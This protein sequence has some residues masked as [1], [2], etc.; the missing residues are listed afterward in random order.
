MK[1]PLSI[2]NGIKNNTANPYD[3]T[4]STKET[5]SDSG[6]WLKERHTSIE[7]WTRGE[8]ILN[9]KPWNAKMKFRTRAPASYTVQMNELYKLIQRQ[10]TW[11]TNHCFHISFETKWKTINL[12][13]SRG[14]CSCCELVCGSDTESVIILEI[15]AL[16][17]AQNALTFPKGE[18]VSSFENV[19]Q[20]S[21]DVKAILTSNLWQTSISK[22]RERLLRLQN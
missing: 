19:N 13:V 12:I 4:K 11:Y 3:R 20:C 5:P 22:K 18:K 21:D 6:G 2:T 10:M 16:C 9:W 8:R 14:K 1:L 17:E 7:H 15:F